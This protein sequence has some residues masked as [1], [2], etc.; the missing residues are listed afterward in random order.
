MNKALGL[1]DHILRHVAELNSTVSPVSDTVVMHPTESS[2]HQDEKIC[3]WE[4]CEKKFENTKQL[5]DHAYKH[6]IYPLRCPRLGWFFFSIIQ[7]K[8]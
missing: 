2:C 5:D 3:R 8:T 6:A 1:R 7:W 4:N